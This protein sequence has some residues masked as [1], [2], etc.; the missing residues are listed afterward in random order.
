ETRVYDW[1]KVF[2]NTINNTLHGICLN[3]AITHSDGRMV[4]DEYIPRIEA[5]QAQI[6]EVTK[7][8]KK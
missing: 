4:W 3:T 5:E 1:P 6:L 8:S 7:W 2:I